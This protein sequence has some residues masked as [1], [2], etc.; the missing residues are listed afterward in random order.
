ML[1]VSAAERRFIEGGVG[2][3]V[4][5]DGRPRLS[6]RHFTLETG[7]IV[8]ANGSA[9]LRLANTDVLV[10]VKVDLG[11]PDRQHPELGKIQFTVECCPSAS[12]EFEGRGAEDLN[13]ELAQAMENLM[14]HPGA[15]DLKSLCLAPGQLCWIIFV[16]VLILDSGGNLFDAVSIASR[17]AL[18]NTRI[19]KVEVFLT[20][21]KPEVEVVDDLAQALRIGIESVPVCVSLFKIGDHYVTDATLEE[22]FCMKV[23]LTVGV[24]RQRNICLTQKGGT[25]GLEPALVFDMLTTAQDLALEVIAGMELQLKEE[26]KSRREAVGFFTAAY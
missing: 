1:R 20:G 16:D 24:N 14:K 9:R 11:E 25:G 22:E 19:P 4:R 13:L 7:L 10:G 17:A 6:Y 26:E 12:P 15:L 18:H 5:G 2:L 8:H 23:R 21:D 3:G